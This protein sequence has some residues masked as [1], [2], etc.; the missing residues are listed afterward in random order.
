MVSTIE[1]AILADHLARVDDAIKWY[2]MGIQLLMSDISAGNYSEL[3]NPQIVHERLKEY[4][5]RV[6]KLKEEL[7]QSKVPKIEEDLVPNRAATTDGA[8]GITSESSISEDGPRGI[9]LQALEEGKKAR[10]KGDFSK[11]IGSENAKH[12]LIEAVLFPLKL[13]S[14]FKENS[15][16]RAWHGILLWGPPGTGKTSLAAAVSKL[17]D[18]SF[19][20]VSASIIMSKY[21]GDSEKVIKA[22]FDEAKILVETKKQPCIIFFDELEAL[23]KKRSSEQSETSSR[24]LTEFLN[25]MGG[26]TSNLKNVLLIGAT[27]LINQ[28]DEAVLRRFEQRILV[29]LPEEK[30]IVSMLTMYLNE[31]KEGGH[32]SHITD[33]QLKEIASHPNM[34]HV[35]GADVATLVREVA[36]KTITDIIK[37]KCF[38]KEND[39]LIPHN[40]EGECG[41]PSMLPESGGTFT[42]D[43]LQT[44]EQ[45]IQYRP[46]E[47]K[48]FMNVLEEKTRAT[49]TPKIFEEYQAA[50]RQQ[51]D[52][53]DSGSSQPDSGENTSK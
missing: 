45:S 1:V 8:R 50:K 47:F 51:G 40:E 4:I 34:K 2:E 31:L 23:F 10:D 35:S 26:A 29:D 27:N 17:V 13:P 46:L 25:R 39:K 49:L 53:K 43:Q 48:D 38:T 22:L 30:D 11:L 41:N 3:G 6:E 20:S 18:C 7:K 15:I 33:E 44:I 37:A 32:E 19:I 5:D 52:T 36:Y 14:A 16:L 12:K 42:L 9:I 24:V 21:V 28:I